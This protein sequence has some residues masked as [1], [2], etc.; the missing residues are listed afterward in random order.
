[1]AKRGHVTAVDLQDA[2]MLLDTIEALVGASGGP[3]KVAGN[4][5]ARFLADKREEWLLCAMTRVEREFR[6]KRRDGTLRNQPKRRCRKVTKRALDWVHDIGSCLFCELEGTDVHAWHEA[7]C[8][9]RNI[10]PENPPQ[11]KRTS[12]VRTELQGKRSQEK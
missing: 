10:D 3:R 7:H 1:M 11:K 6:V 5:I 2:E 4:T 9:L 12:Q 8:P